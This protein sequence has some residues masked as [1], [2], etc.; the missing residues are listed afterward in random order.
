VLDPGVSEASADASMVQVPQVSVVI[1]SVNGLPYPLDCLKAL[2]NQEGGV[3]TEV[4]VAD[5]TGPVTVAAIQEHYP[6]ATILAFNEQKSVPWL[7]SAGIQA[8]RAQLVAVTEDHC[9]PRPDWLS[10]LVKVSE[11]TGWAAVGGGV[12]NDSTERLVDWAVY[13]CEYSGLMN[14]V[15]AGPTATIP[16]MNVVYDL[17]QLAPVREV[18]AEGLWENFLHD[19]IRAAGYT[20]GLDPSIVVGHKKRFTVRMFLAERYYYSRAFGGYRAHGAPLRRR[21]GWAATMPLLPALIVARVAR[22]VLCRR[23]HTGWF[24]KALP[25]VLLFSLTWTVG[26]LV[27]YLT[28]PGDSLVRIR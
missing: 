25:L 2:S 12:E 3:A 13:F 24:V 4:I 9:V 17:D 14:P 28:G 21:L 7:R 18:F 10:R 22:N 26:E 8:A 11:R 20:I 6:Q 1:A 15:P 5:C 16:G 23:R 19:R 27:G